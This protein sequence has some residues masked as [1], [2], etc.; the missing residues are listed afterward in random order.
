[1]FAGIYY[2]WNK[3]KV[4]TRCFFRALQK[5]CVQLARPERKRVKSWCGN[6]LVKW[7]V[8][9]ID[10]NMRNSNRPNGNPF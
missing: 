8:M 3:Y 1:M 4:E 10:W 2:L 6:S 7:L 5:L 9:K